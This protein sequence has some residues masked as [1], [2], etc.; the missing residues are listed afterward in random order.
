MKTM[1]DHARAYRVRRSDKM[2]RYEAALREI[3]GHRA[4]AA[5]CNPQLMRDIARQA[6]NP[7][8]NNGE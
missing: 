3:A 7:T 5:G 2:A 8:T 1:A 6:L 4:D